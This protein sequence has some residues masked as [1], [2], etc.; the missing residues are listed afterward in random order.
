[1]DCCVAAV[2]GCLDAIWMSGN[3]ILHFVVLGA[4]L[5]SQLLRL[6]M[7]VDIGIQFG[8]FSRSL[9]SLG[10]RFLLGSSF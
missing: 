9:R 10:T 6:S 4:E 7:R 1:M 2:D 5:L 3:H 8:L